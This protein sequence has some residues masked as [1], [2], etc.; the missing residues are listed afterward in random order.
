MLETEL[1]PALRFSE[2]LL[3]IARRA[4]SE[5]GCGTSREGIRRAG[6][7]VEEASF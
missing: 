6:G 5:R 7:A 3:E 4:W 1:Q 2:D